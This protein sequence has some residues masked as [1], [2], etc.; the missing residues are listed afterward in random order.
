MWVGFLKVAGMETK[1]RGLVHIAKHD[2]YNL[3]QSVDVFVSRRLLVI[4]LL[5]GNRGF[6]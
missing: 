1:S 3:F 5:C 2:I 6:L 4:T